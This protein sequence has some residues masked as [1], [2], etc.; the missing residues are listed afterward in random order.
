M[1]CQWL[2]RIWVLYSHHC[3]LIQVYFTLSKLITEAS[4]FSTEC[5]GAHGS[6]TLQLI[7]HLTFST[8][9]DS[10]LYRPSLDVCWK[11]DRSCTHSHHKWVCS[12]RLEGILSGGLQVS[13]PWK[14]WIIFI[15]NLARAIKPG[16]WVESQEF[17]LMA[18][19][20]DDTLSS[21]SHVLKWCRLMNEGSLMGGF[22]LR[23][24]SN[25]IRAA[26][27]LTFWRLSCFWQ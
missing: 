23:I 27:K 20:D 24:T 15:V 5:R 9:S 16:G 22:K 17:D 7:V 25:E 1:I 2:E 19:T 8:V 3:S 6:F 4:Q 21:D 12:T 26:M 18:F 10:W 11:L 13:S 14:Y